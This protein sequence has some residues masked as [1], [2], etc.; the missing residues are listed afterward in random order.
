MSFLSTAIQD[1]L[2]HGEFC[3]VASLTPNGPHCT[4]L[5][6]A[7]SGGRLWLTTSRRSVKARSWALDPSMAGLVRHGDLAVTFTGTVRTFDLLDR[8]TWGATVSDAPQLARASVKFSRKNARF[9]AGYAVDAKQVPF[10]WTPPGRVF[11]GIDVGRTAL[12]D[13]EGVQEGWSRWGGEVSS[14]TA[15]TATRKGKAAF[16]PL[17]L[18]VRSAMGES[19]EGALALAGPQG[20][21]V[22]PCRWLAD[23]GAL[24]AGLPVETLALA[25]AG[26]EVAVALTVDRASAWRAR[27]MVGAMVQGAGSVYTLAALESG[28]RSAKSILKSIG[29][30]LDALVRIAPSRLVWWHGW[31]SGSAAA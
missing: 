13:D 29:P 26:P 28:A 19:G 31:S 24:Y 4:P 18:D 6:F 2:E 3:S 30:G 10:A 17:P 14:H 22:V 25:D 27:E 20:P 5:V 23:G 7:L 15:F 21:T 8:G 16:D 1:V 9:F 11:V 12:V